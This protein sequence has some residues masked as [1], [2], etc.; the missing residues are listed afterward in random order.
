MLVWTD[1]GE[2]IAVPPVFWENGVSAFKRLKGVSIVL[3]HLHY[4]KQDPFEFHDCAVH[5]E[6]YK[7]LLLQSC[8][9]TE[10]YVRNNRSKL[11][12]DPELKRVEFVW[13]ATLQTFNSN[14]WG[15]AVNVIDLYF[16]RVSS[17]YERLK[18]QKSA[19]T[20]A[21]DSSLAVNA[22]N[23]TIISKVLVSHGLFLRCAISD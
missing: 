6:W 19:A 11:A 22:A 5:F 15:N 4:Q 20:T 16:L 12:S 13:S 10:D 14:E 3:L 1:L 17:P 18:L 23:L 2:D 9:Y 8:S 7:F 21:L